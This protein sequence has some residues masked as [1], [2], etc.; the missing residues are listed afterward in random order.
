MKV[1]LYEANALKDYV[2]RFFA[3]WQVPMEEAKI[4]A[5]VLVSANLRGIDSHGV[6]RLHGYYAGRL[7]DGRIDP[8][9][10]L[11]LVKETPF[12]LLFDGGNGLGPVIA[13]WAMKRCIEKAS[14]TG[15]SMVGVR[16]SNHFGIAAYYGMMALPHG[17][18]GVSLTNSRPLMVPTYAANA[19]MGTN[20][21]CLTAPAN[22]EFPFVLDM[23]TSV[24]SVGKV[25]YHQKK[26]EPIPQGWGVD[27]KGDLTTDPIDVLKG[28]GVLPLGGDDLHS[29]YK[30][31]G[32]SM[33]V[34]LLCGVLSGAAFGMEVGHIHEAKPSNVGHFFAAFKIENF[35]PL[36]EFKS[37][38]DKF[39][40][41]LKNADKAR[42]RER[43]YIPGEKEFE[44]EQ[45]RTQKGVPLLEDTVE[46]LSKTGAEVGVKF[47]ITCLSSEEYKEA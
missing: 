14:Q 43:I 11:T 6:I 3:Q 21:I 16:N 26:G 31:Y 4:A 12:N 41:S 10:K 42:G 46:S 33:M 47:D 8:I 44:M 19:I 38:M 37:R 35:I 7:R 32:L 13:Y 45:E 22:D 34:D 40:Q 17:M 1:Y 2:S 5:D 39:I 23:A 20:P 27:G 15:L 24:V 9:S 25:Q 30:G 36:N 28:G 18:I 29:G